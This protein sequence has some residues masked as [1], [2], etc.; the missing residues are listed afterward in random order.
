MK[1]KLNMRSKIV[2]NNHIIEQVN[3]S[4]YLVYTTITVTNNR[5]LEIRMYCI[6]SIKMCS[7]IQ[8]MLNNKMRKQMLLIKQK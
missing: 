1:G 6:K 2:I 3:S 8:R 5:D 7:T 4:N